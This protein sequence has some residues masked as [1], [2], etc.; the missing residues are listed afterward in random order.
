MKQELLAADPAETVAGG[1]QRS[2]VMER[3]VVP[4]SKVFADFGS[5]VGVVLLQIIER[6]VGKNYT[7]AECIIRAVALNHDNFRIGIAQFHGNGAVK[8]GRATT[9]TCNPHS[10]ILHTIGLRKRMRVRI[11]FQA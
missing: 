7:P 1:H 9:Q 3:N 6:L 10:R 5:A 2:P 8:T 4:I 11:E